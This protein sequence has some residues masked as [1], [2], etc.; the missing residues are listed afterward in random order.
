L[1]AHSASVP[2]VSYDRGH[3]FTADRAI[4]NSVAMASTFLPWM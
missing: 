4:S 1:R 3:W 2:A